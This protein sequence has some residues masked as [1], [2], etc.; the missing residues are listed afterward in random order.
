MK[1]NQI[2]ELVMALLIIGLLMPYVEVKYVY[3]KK[4]KVIR[5]DWIDGTRSELK[6]K[7]W[8]HIK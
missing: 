3:Y 5:I 2:L 6:K 8:V 1:I 7:K 4:G